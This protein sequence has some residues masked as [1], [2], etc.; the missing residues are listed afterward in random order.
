M[1]GTKKKK[2]RKKLI[3]KAERLTVFIGYREAWRRS[4]KIF[5]DQCDFETFIALLPIMIII[6]ITI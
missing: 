5:V 1:E 2:P 6:I 4:C 3:K